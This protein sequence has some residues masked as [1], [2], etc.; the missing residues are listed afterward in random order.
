MK[1]NLN[2][3]MYIHVL[4]GEL[5]MTQ[6]MTELLR[7]DVDFQLLE[8]LTIKELREELEICKLLEL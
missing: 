1:Q 6:Q 2:R 4:L 8:K 3:K 5:D 7:R